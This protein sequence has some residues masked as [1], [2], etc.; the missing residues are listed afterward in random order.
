MIA[1]YL[2][3]WWGIG[4]AAWFYIV[5][6]VEPSTTIDLETLVFGLFVGFIGPVMLVLITGF[7]ASNWWDDHKYTVL[8]KPLSKSQLRRKEKK[9]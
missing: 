4:F 6:W 1:L 3:A 2:A 9:E 8:I 5:W 7:Y